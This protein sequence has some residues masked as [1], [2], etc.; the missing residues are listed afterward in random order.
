MAVKYNLPIGV[1]AQGKK[2]VS[3]PASKMLAVLLLRNL[4]NMIFKNINLTV[5]E[6]YANL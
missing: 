2:S 1:V 6:Y 5:T 3:P 4:R